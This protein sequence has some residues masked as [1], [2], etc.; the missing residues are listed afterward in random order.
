V[1]L[2][3]VGEML[4]WLAS[5]LQI[6]PD[7][8]IM[9]TVVGFVAL[10][11]VMIFAGQYHPLKPEHKKNIKESKSIHRALMR[12]PDNKKRIDILRATHP[13]VFEELILTAMKSPFRKIRRNHRYTGDGGIDG[14]VR[15]HGQWHYVQAKR[16]KN[17]ISAEHV[18][19]FIE[20]C[21]KEG[22]PGLFVHTG[23]TGEKSKELIS[24]TSICHMIS[25]QAL[26]SML[27]GEVSVE[28]LINNSLASG[29]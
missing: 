25:G 21:K 27:A 9:I 13:N 14:Q 7:Q 1:E 18:R 6:H 2:T 19:E 15:I 17:H 3:A 26:C 22:K 10:S 8:I 20:I 28:S 5:K 11:L 12:I 4:Y 23:I 24:G 29:S 16:Y